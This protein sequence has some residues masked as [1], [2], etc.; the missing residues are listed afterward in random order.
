MGVRKS[1][2]PVITNVGVFTFG[3]KFVSERCMYCSVLSHGLPGN[4]YL[5]VN[6]ISEVRTKLYQL[7]TGYSAA[8]ARKRSVCSMVQ[9]VSTPPP[10]P[11]VTKRLFGSM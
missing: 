4:Q 2:S 6:G 3:S 11:P 7:M 1:A 5:E 8:A 10:L 9:Q